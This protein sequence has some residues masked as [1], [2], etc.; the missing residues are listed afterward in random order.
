M[1]ESK[2]TFLQMQVGGAFGNSSKSD[3]TG[4]CLAPKAFNLVHM[5]SASHKFILAMIAPEMFAVSHIDQALR[6]PPHIRIDHTVQSDLVTNNRLQ[7]GFPAV[8]TRSVKPA[9]SVGKV[10]KRGFFRT[11]FVPVSLSKLARRTTW[12][13]PV[14][15]SAPRWK[16]GTPCRMSCS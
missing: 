1:I 14:G 5:R 11:S 15:E 12:R 6:P 2:S 8:W 7:R 9:H 3:E 13:E 4:F 16:R 10:Q